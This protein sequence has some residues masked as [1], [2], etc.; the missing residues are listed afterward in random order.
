MSSTSQD[1][2]HH[3]FAE[4]HH[5][6]SE[7]KFTITALPNAEIRAVEALVH[8]LYAVRRI[9]SDLDDPYS[10]PVELQSSHNV[11]IERL[12]RD[13]RKD[14]LEA[15]RKIFEYLEQNNLLDMSNSIQRLC[16]FVVFQPRIQ[17]SL[18]RTADA[19][20]HHRLRTEGHKSPVAI[21]E[22]SREYAKTR[23][24]WTG[25][26]GDDIHTAQHPSYGFEPEETPGDHQVQEEDSDSIQVN[27]DGDV[28]FV[29]EAFEHMDFDFRRDDGNWGIEVYCEAVQRLKVFVESL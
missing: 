19:W 24:Y 22:L 16:L 14:S 17:E 23:G 27:E 6:T 26:P 18:S 20:N 12:W 9:L 7:A 13:V 29:R 3:F 28:T 15:Y 5:L 8:K 21:Y 10:D 11:H 1:S 2:A 4:A 25:D